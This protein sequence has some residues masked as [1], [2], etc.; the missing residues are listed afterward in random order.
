[1]H[2]SKEFLHSACRWVTL[3]AVILSSAC[4]FCNSNSSSCEIADMQPHRRFVTV[5]YDGLSVCG[6]PALAVAACSNEGG[7]KAGLRQNHSK[8]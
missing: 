4:H 8:L 7:D 2:P 5:V 3:D 6:P 1:M